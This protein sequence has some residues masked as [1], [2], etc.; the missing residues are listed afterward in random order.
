MLLGSY[1]LSDPCFFETNTM[2]KFPREHPKLS[3]WDRPR[4]DIPVCT[5]THQSNPLLHVSYIPS[6]LC[7]KT[8]KRV[9]GIPVFVAAAVSR[10]CHDLPAG[11]LSATIRSYREDLAHPNRCVGEVGTAVSALFSDFTKIKPLKV[12][13][14]AYYASPVDITLPTRVYP[15]SKGETP[16]FRT[17]ALTFILR[18]ENF[19]PRYSPPI[20]VII[21][22]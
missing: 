8:T 15:S 6:N 11:N 14:M 12:T 4:G 22:P 10:R 18:M 19:K 20:K 1:I 2:K 5:L 7:Y 3:M 16:D 9:A 13:F 21:D 17:C